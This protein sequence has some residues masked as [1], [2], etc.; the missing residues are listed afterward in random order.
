MVEPLFV[1]SNL[2][3]SDKVILTGDEAKHAISV[4]RMRVGEAISVTNGKGLRVRGLVAEL[5]KHELVIKVSE[6]SQEIEDEP[7][8]VL[9]Q[10]LAKGDR[11][12]LAIQA[13]TEL[14]VSQIIP[15][16][17]NRSVTRW[18]GQ[19][20]STGQA[21]WQQI[22]TEAAKQSLRSFIPEVLAVRSSQELVGDFAGFD[23]VLVLD[24]SADTKL[25]DIK[26][27]DAGKI[28]IVVGPEGGI[29]PEELE[30]FGTE[31]LVSLG[32]NI[33]RTSTAGPA[34]LAALTLNR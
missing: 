33:L 2:K 7:R 6:S 32:K 21:R 23:L 11:D 27:P 34:L 10:A 8:Y 13:A 30:L 31:R 12:E 5:S 24:P 25:R 17:A 20:K 26:V 16:A 19:K 9:V 29:S 14:G 15:W 18:E 4:R 1:D 22:V 3:V 28:A